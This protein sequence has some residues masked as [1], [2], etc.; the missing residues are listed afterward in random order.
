MIN[1]TDTIQDKCSKKIKIAIEKRTSC[2]I[3]SDVI[4]S[5]TGD[6]ISDSQSAVKI[7]LG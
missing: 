1:N 3:V 5:V 4:D 2:D 7:N 6:V